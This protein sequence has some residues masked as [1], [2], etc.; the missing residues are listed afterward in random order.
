MLIGITTDVLELLFQVH[1]SVIVTTVLAAVRLFA[2]LLSVSQ[3][4]LEFLVDLFQGV[5]LL[6]LVVELALVVAFYLF[7]LLDLGLKF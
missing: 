1:I 3:L 2:V 5:D 4:L 7:V 6:F